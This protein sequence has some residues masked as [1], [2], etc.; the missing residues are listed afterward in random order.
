MLG[1]FRSG[2]NPPLVNYCE[3]VNNFMKIGIVVAGLPPEVL[4]GAETQATQA[5]ARLAARHEVR[6]FT[7]SRTIP[8]PLRGRSG[9]LVIQRSRARR[10]GLRFALDLC[11]TLATLWRHR[12]ALDVLLAY[13]TVID[14]LIAVIAGRLWSIPTVVWVRSEVE[15]SF[16]A[17]R[18]A[19]WLSP[20]VFRHAD[21]VAVQSALLRDALLAAL[22]GAGQ[23]E[24]ANAVEAKVQ[25]I[26]NGVEIA[27]QPL[28]ED[29]REVLFVGRLAP[30]K[31]VSHLIAALRA[32]PQI[33]LTIVGDGPQRALLQSMAVDL[34]NVRFAGSCP[35]ELIPDHMAAAGILVLPSLRNEGL[36][37]VLLEAMARGLV[38]VASRNAGIPDLIDDGIS[39]LLVTPGDVAGLTCALQ[40]VHDD[41]ALRNDLRTHARDAVRAYAWPA[42]LAKLERTLLD[43]IA[44]GS[45]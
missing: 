17:S 5:A 6:I 43:V 36:P 34:D 8:E 3:P 26:A 14:G 39:G 23:G 38:V 22:R 19:R 30:D 7:R 33:R 15:F 20:W 16:A 10:P 44:A 9:C 40:R 35:P 12:H 11:T 24:L 13:Q 41:G 45:R 28:P 4:G 1:D 18:Q 25:V 37:N 32:C 21:A 29:R 2:R 42:V 27:D 31:G